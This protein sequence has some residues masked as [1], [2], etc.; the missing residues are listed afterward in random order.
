LKS[1]RF[2]PLKNGVCDLDGFLIGVRCQLDW[3]DRLRK[4][5]ERKGEQKYGPV[6]PETDPR[7][8]IR[9]ALEELFD[10][11]NYLEWAQEKGEI[12]EGCFNK[13]D[14]DIREVIH[15][16]SFACKDKNE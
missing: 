2:L 13:V 15:N 10:S 16:L 7:C 12:S 9:E 1:L 5:R 11:L 4:E 8:F 14:R 6:N 3:I